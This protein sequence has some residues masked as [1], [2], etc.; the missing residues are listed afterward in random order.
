MDSPLPPKFNDHRHCGSE[1]VTF[2]I[3]HVTS[4]KHL[5][6]GLCDSMARSPSL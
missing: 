6:K 1:D 2:V 4:R 3:F 5:F